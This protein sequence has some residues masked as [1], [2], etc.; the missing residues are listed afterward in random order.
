MLLLVLTSELRLSH[1]QCFEEDPISRQAPK[2]VVPRVHSVVPRDLEV[3]LVP[4][5]SEAPH[6]PRTAPKLLKINPLPWTPAQGCQIAKFHPFLSLDCA[7]VEGVGA[8]SKERKGSNF[9]A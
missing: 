6:I 9:A 7:R 4:V 3:E 8:Q 5:H 1:I 2:L